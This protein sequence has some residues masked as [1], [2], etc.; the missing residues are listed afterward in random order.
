M[1][2]A[3]YFRKPEAP[4]TP[5]ERRFIREYIKTS[6]PG[7]ALKRA[8]A[9][10]DDSKYSSRAKAMLQQD[11]I[12]REIENVMAEIHDEA[13]ANGTEVLEYF[14]SVMR[15]EIKDQFGLDASL[16]ERTKAAQELAKR[17]VDLENRRAGEADNVIQIKLDWGRD[18]E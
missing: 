1:K 9:K 7:E 2:R 14:T 8:G 13:V 12:R 4:L 5:L 15:G 18:E 17:T 6:N 16:S 10:L 3:T 11:R